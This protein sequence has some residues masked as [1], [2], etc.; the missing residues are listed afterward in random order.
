M[1]R[2]QRAW[3]VRWITTSARESGGGGQGSYH[4]AQEAP[5]PGQSLQEPPGAPQGIK[6]DTQERSLS[7]GE[8]GAP[9]CSGTEELGT[10][11]ETEERGRGGEEEQVS[12]PTGTVQ[13]APEA[14]GAGEGAKGTTTTGGPA[15]FPRVHQS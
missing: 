10:G 11:D 9:A 12:S 6:D 14:G 13:E 15:E 8:A 5:Q 2:G 1:C 7:G 4:P 3:E